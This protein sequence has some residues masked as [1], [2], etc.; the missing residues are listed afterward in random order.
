MTWIWTRT[1][2]V[3]V[4]VLTTVPM[5]SAQILDESPGAVPTDTG[6]EIPE[7]QS[8]EELVFELF[9]PFFVIFFLNRLALQQALILILGEPGP[10]PDDPDEGEINRYATVL[11]LAFT[12]SLI[13]TS[14]WSTVKD[15]TNL[16]GSL[17]VVILSLVLLYLGYIVLRP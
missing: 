6:F 1:C 2:L 16:I 4:A 10:R 17:P 11:A 3:F 13:P 5:S 8:T 7:Y 12:S 14:L 15:V 9:V